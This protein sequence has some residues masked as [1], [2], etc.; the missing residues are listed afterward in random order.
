MNNRDFGLDYFSNVS[1]GAST[2]NSYDI[3]EFGIYGE[4]NLIPVS[5]SRSSTDDTLSLWSEDS[6]GINTSLD[7]FSLTQGSSMWDDLDSSYQSND[8]A[9][10][11]NNSKLSQH[12]TEEPISN[13]NHGFVLFCLSPFN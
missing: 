2:F 11:N 8:T 10:S 6:N 1:D 7:E 3:D 12:I 5:S 4:D 13:S 9:S